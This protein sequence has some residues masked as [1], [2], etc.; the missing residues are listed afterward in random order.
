MELDSHLQGIINLGGLGMPNYAAFLLTPVCGQNATSN[1]SVHRYVCLSVSVTTTATL[2]IFCRR[3]ERRDRLPA[4][5]GSVWFGELNK[6][7]RSAKRLP[8]MKKQG[9]AIRQYVD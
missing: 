2:I 8:K 9:G 3:G 7:M 4:L 5:G 6:R 1:Y